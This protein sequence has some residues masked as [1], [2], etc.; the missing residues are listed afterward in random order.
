[1]FFLE[2]ALLLP[3]SPNINIIVADLKAHLFNTNQWAMIVE[4]PVITHVM[5]RFAKDCG[6][7]LKSSS[8]CCLL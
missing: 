2:R 3:K 8:V 4:V 5:A 6:V 1:M 7:V